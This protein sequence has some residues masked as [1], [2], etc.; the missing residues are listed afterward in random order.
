LKN[1][2]RGFAP[3]RRRAKSEEFKENSPREREFPKKKSCQRWFVIF[4]KESPNPMDTKS[5]SRLKMMTKVIPLKPETREVLRKSL[6]DNGKR[7]D[8]K[9]K[10]KGK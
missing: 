2:E 1:S 7:P 3:K 6:E 10:P 4:V 8:M 9:S 5:T